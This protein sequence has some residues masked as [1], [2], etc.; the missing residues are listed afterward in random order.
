MNR[1]LKTLLVKNLFVSIKEIQLPKTHSV[2]HQIA[3]TME[4]IRMLFQIQQTMVATAVILEQL[5]YAKKI[6]HW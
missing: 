1:V 3:G 4:Q 2:D 5:Q 6:A